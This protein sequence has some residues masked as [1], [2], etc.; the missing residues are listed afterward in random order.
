MRGPSTGPGKPSELRRTD[1]RIS[2]GMKIGITKCRIS[3]LP[4]LQ[5]LS[6]ATYAD[7]FQRWFTPDGLRQYMESEFNKQRLESE[8]LNRLSHFFFLLVDGAPTGYMKINE[9]NAQTAFKDLESLAIER[10]NVTRSHQGRGAYATK[11]SPPDHSPAHGSHPNSGC[12]LQASSS[13]RE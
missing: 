1:Q 6:R 10:I 2:P 11:A 13:R 7:T 12:H 3:D 4:L 8:L 5:A 9:A